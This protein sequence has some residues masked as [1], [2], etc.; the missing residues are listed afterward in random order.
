MPKMEGE[1]ERTRRNA[2]QVTE[3][4]ERL[5]DQWLESL[6]GLQ[7]VSELL[8]EARRLM[9]VAREAEQQEAW[10]LELGQLTKRLAVMDHATKILAHE[11]QAIHQ[12]DPLFEPNLEAVEDAG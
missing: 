9:G 6:N 12:V 2:Q 8:E 4:V 5:E 3:R 7:E 10:Q 1:I 11:L